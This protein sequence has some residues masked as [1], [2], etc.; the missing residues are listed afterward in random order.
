MQQLTTLV[1]RSLFSALGDFLC[2]PASS[3]Y[4]LKAR[5]L[6][7]NWQITSGEIL[8]RGIFF[9]QSFTCYIVRNRNL[10]CLQGHIC[11]SSGFWGK[12]FSE[13]CFSAPSLQMHSLLFFLQCFSR[14]S[15]AEF[16]TPSFLTLWSGNN[17][18]WGLCLLTPVVQFQFPCRVW[19][20]AQF[21]SM[22][23]CV[24]LCL[25][26]H[27]GTSLGRP[28]YWSHS[29]A[30]VKFPEVW[31]MG[32]RGLINVVRPPRSWHQVV[33]PSYCMVLLWT[34]RFSCVFMGIAYNTSN[35]IV[36]QEEN[37]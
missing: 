13:V 7:F 12:L 14:S 28:W 19:V 25:A 4:V 30:H 10:T 35:P 1:S 22:T 23:L 21:L 3:A 36:H 8:S 29:P 15:T 37:G 18:E 24:C 5:V 11:N 9:K 17:S 31:V 2:F 32:H 34:F 27:P 26:S 20:G 6:Y 16:F 33:C